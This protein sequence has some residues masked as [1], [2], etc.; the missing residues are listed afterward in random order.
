MKKVIKLL[1]I[2]T[3]ISNNLLYGNLEKVSLQLEW[4]HQF[5]FAGFYTALE[6]G[7][8]KD[9]GLDL[10]IKEFQDGINISQDVIDGKSTFGISSSALILERLKNKPVIL[11]ASYFKQNALAL[12]TKPYIK[13]PADLKNKKIMALDWEMGHT[14]LGVMLKDYG[15]TSDSFTLINH[16]YKIDKFVNG[17]VDAMSIFIT[18]QPYELDKLGIK[19]NILNPANFG[20]YSYD[21]E[22]FTSENIIN[23]NPEMVENFIE[24]TNKGWEYAFKNKE[25]IVDLI[26]NKY[27][28]RKTKESLLY[29][30]NQTEQIFKT[31]IFKIGAIAPELI[32]LN[33]DLYT[34]LGLVDKNLN[35]TF[36]LDSY[37]LRDNYKR[38]IPFSKEEKEYLKKH[39]TIKVHNESNWPPFN[40][41]LKGKPT[42]FSIEYMDLVA[43]KLGINIEYIS[44]YSWN[45]FIEKLKKDEIDVMLNIS[46]TAQREKDFI[47]TSDYVKAID[48]IFIKKSDI[49][50]KNI[51]D[52]R[53][54]TL[55]VIK[56]FYE[57]ELL[58]AYYPDIKLLLVKDSLEALEKVAFGEADGAVDNFA[59]GNYYI[60]NNHISNLKPGFSIDD[61]RFNLKM[62]LATNK[63][64]IILR[65]LLEKGKEQ[66]SEKE[67]ISLKRKWINSEEYEKISNINL[68]KDEKNYLAKK[69]VITMC[70]D[71][72]WEPFEK[73]NEKGEHEGIAADIINLISSKLGI[74]IE[75]IPTKSWEESI[76]F[77]KEKKCDILSFLNETQKRKEWLNFTE[78]IFEDPNVIVGRIE[79]EDIKDLSKIKASIAL[80]KDTAMSERFQKDFPNLVIIPT[81]SEDETF[82]FVENK[83]A[84]FTIRSLIVTAHTIKKNGLFN[85]KIISQPLE[86][87]NI[88][89]IGVLKDEDL[90]KNIL[91]KAIKTISKKELEHIVNNHISVKIPSETKYLSVF[92]YILIFIIL[93][94]IVI[95][96]WNHQLRKK[97]AIEIER[98]ST[99]QDLMFRQNKQAELG[100][101]IGN[102]SHQWRDSLTK[103]GYI[104]L[105][106]RARILQE[107]DI[108]KEFLNKSTLEIEKSLDFM[109][110][111]MQNFLDYYK[112][113]L[114]TL[115]FEVYDSIK[116]AL[117]IIDTKIKYSNLEI[118]FIGDFTIK[119]NG[120]RNE[121]MQVWINLIINSI[122]I[123]EK[124]EIK[125]PQILISLSQEEIEFEDNCGKI[126]STLLE[127]MKEERYRGIGIKMAK[128]IAN[129]NN[130][131]MIIINSE[132]GAIFKFIENR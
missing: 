40:Y 81:N 87:K 5:E 68:T 100:N 86:Y 106:L 20:I 74:E 92:I 27:T 28:K 69:R 123:A 17:E 126:D 48:T 62:Y 58:K 71:P 80:P 61:D 7:Y 116:S 57:E 42:G 85:L 111:T 103:I 46:K 54:K 4:K 124:R 73:I 109:S 60:Q 77:S 44:G 14:S 49:N 10:Q 125:N 33:A 65:D 110:E 37:Y 115:N 89:R 91:N 6:K 35:I 53:G 129:K 102:I 47:F 41:N 23:K 113:S 67:I 12:V 101:L 29:E 43:S 30:A 19:Y 45:E 127:E 59:V 56:G 9:V 128:E 75:L 25:E 2:L 107:K 105:N 95:L 13:T 90:L 51:E 16:D 83:K 99:Q 79:N 26:Y 94:V 24:A 72:D 66:I 39:P 131:K 96:L 108:S 117:S 64:N 130:K 55:A 76:I 97:I 88:L 21:V 8:Y 38:L 104:N 18:S 34:K 112:P 50:L 22:L 11:I 119:I 84:D 1:F 70:T 114:N 98:N 120:I 93:I 82:K 15:I 31:N 36:A 52:F 132:D 122:N 63:N 118:N 78:P 3:I 121:W 32:K